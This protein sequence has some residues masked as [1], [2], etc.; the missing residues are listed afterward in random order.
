LLVTEQIEKQRPI[1][2]LN[3]FEMFDHLGANESRLGLDDELAE[4]KIFASKSALNWVIY[5]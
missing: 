3:N 5:D 1:E 2:A 4:N